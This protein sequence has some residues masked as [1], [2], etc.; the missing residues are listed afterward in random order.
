VPNV[1]AAG[2]AGGPW[3]GWKSILL[4]HA[5]KWLINWYS[6]TPVKLKVQQYAISSKNDFMF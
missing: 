2:R 5:E 6:I 3:A 4:I 1:R